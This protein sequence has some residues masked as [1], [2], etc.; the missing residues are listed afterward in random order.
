MDIRANGRVSGK[1]GA[2]S[3]QRNNRVL[4][5]HAAV[6]CIYFLILL[7]TVSVTE[8]MAVFLFSIPC[9]V[10]YS[11]SFYLSY[12][13]KTRGLLW[14]NYGV[15]TAFILAFVF[16]F[17]WDCGVQHFIFVMIALV[18]VTET[19]GLK[20]KAAWTI[21]FCLFR[22]LMY[23]Y[24]LFVSPVYT[25]SEPA[26]I[27]F[28]VINTIAIFAAFFSCFAV[29]IQDMKRMEQSLDEVQIRLKRYEDEDPLTGLLNRRSMME[30]L[31]S[32]TIGKQQGGKELP[33][34]SI[35]IGDIDFFGK[36]NDKKG[37]DCGDIILKQ[38]AYQFQIFM[39]G[40][41]R[42]ARWGG[43]E[44]LFVF[45]NAGG[46]DAYYY[47]TRLQQQIRGLDF[48][49]K[50]EQ[51]KLTMTY[52]LMEYNAEKSIDFCIVEAGKKMAMGK[53]SGRNTII[54]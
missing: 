22:I 43:E 40:K 14:L 5:L 13:V 24:T 52:G 28:Q 11:I 50:D 47:L 7:L 8:S 27:T 29:C 16:L 53:E 1:T 23:I 25:L 34:I 45:E 6:M 46:E 26:C 3:M 10:A 38:L 15:T 49:W 9:F 44:F 39:E 2:D 18:F 17:G 30:Y 4:R 19:G 33:Q 21:F 35:A 51:I 42:A 54:Y 41:G 37:H 31:E 48:P 20:K 12:K 36:V 32:V